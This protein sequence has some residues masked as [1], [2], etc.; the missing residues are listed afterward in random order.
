MLGPPNTLNLVAGPSLRIASENIRR[1]KA[2]IVKGGGKLVSD[3][4]FSLETDRGCRFLALPQS[5]ENVRGLSLG[6]DENDPYSTVVDAAGNKVPGSGG[7]CV[8][9]EAAFIS[10]DEFFT[11]L[12]PVCSR[13]AP[14]NRLIFSSTPNGQKGAFYSYWIDEESGFEKVHADWT[15]ATHLDPK[16]IAQERRRMSE[17]AFSA[18]WEA[19]FVSTGGQRYFSLDMWDELL[20]V[21]PAVHQSPT[22]ADTIPVPEETIHRKRALPEF[23]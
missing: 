23:M 16:F 4:Q 5:K 14:L 17:A 7:I 15:M 1:T 11:A 8:V 21:T 19:S 13:R 22:D 6:A 2:Y 9:D 18:E 10:D 3:N 20:G 12:T